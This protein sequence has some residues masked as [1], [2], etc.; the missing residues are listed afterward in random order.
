MT[1]INTEKGIHT[2]NVV[3]RSGGA[4]ALGL[5]LKRK[6]YRYR[7]QHHQKESRTRHCIPSGAEWHSRFSLSEYTY[8][9]YL[10]PPSHGLAKTT[11]R[12]DNIC[13]G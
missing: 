5:T 4:A 1:T 9:G 2:L 12:H 7:V 6:K 3:G 13:I 11:F 8:L 10:R